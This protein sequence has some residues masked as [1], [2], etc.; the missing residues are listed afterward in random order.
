MNWANIG[1]NE[2]GKK[3]FGL[4]DSLSIYTKYGNV[5]I[6]FEE[7]IYKVSEVEEYVGVKDNIIS[8]IHESKEVIVCEGH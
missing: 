1:K 2:V 7:A 8:E 6:L 4:S 3:N 5:F